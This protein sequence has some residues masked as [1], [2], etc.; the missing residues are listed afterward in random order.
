MAVRSALQNA[1]DVQ[2]AKM[3]PDEWQTEVSEGRQGPLSRFHTVFTGT[4]VR[5]VGS[6]EGVHPTLD[7]FST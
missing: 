6:T 3:Q 2:V 5:V 4:G 7:S 1:G